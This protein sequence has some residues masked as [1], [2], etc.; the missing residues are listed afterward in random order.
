MCNLDIRQEIKTAGLF[1][2]QVADCMG[3]ADYTL[4]RKLRKELSK[5]DKAAIRG[6]I[7]TLKSDIHVSAQ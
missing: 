6:A 5:D 7:L 2:W 4:S 3:V 1:L